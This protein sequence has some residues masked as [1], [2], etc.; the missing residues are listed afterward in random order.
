MT[1]RQFLIQNNALQFHISLYGESE[2]DIEII[3]VDNS[4]WLEKRLKLTTKGAFIY[5]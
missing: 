5:E 4:L 1:F 3:N 2:L